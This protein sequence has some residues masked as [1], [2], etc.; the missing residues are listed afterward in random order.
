MNSKNAPDSPSGFVK[1]RRGGLTTEK[2]KEVGETKP[3]EP[4]AIQTPKKEVMIEM[5][6]D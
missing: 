2:M 5:T 1:M 4:A 6:E 3:D